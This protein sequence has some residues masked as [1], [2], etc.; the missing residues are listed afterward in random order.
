M[1]P[2]HSFL[3]LPLVLAAGSTTATAAGA[4]PPVLVELFTSEGCSS[5]PP[6]DAFLADLQRERALPGNQVIVLGEHVDYWD[7]L[8]WVDPYA[9]PGSGQRQREYARTLRQ[10]T[11]YTPQMVIDGTYGKV[12]S[13]RS[14]VRKAITAAASRP[15]AQVTVAPA[16]S[17]AG[18]PEATFQVQVEGLHPGAGEGPVVLYL[19]V[20]ENGL[21]S[22]VTRGENAGRIL[23]HTAVARRLLRIAELAPGNDHYATAVQVPLDPAWKRPN[24]GVVAFLQSAGTGRILGVASSLLGPAQLAGAL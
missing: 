3:F 10:P 5:C 13:D 19:A 4:P 20:T 16:A 15:K 21:T 7:R 14:E 17:R 11:V 22:R 23:S 18:H 6:A 8:G 9:S 1:R 2:T 12:G 24:L